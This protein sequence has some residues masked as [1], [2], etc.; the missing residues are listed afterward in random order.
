MTEITWFIKHKRHLSFIMIILFIIS[1]LNSNLLS[2]SIHAAY[3]HHYYYE[4]YM[5]HNSDNTEPDDPTPN[6]KILMFYYT[7]SVDSTSSSGTTTDKT[8][9]K[10]Y[11][12]NSDYYKITFHI[13]LFE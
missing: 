12:R 4:D 8:T 5:F 6:D 9:I 10:R 7:S 1:I 13:G 11:I 3:T 2:I